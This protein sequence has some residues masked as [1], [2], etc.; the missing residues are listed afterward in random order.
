MIECQLFYYFSGERI[1]PME[2][3]DSCSGRLVYVHFKHDVSS[4]EAA[5]QHHDREHA[6]TRKNTS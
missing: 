4:I 5:V 2:G 6:P 1:E 3:D